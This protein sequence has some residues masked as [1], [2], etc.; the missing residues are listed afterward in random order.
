MVP[1]AGFTPTDAGFN[2]GYAIAKSQQLSPGIY[3]CMNGRIFDP[4]EVVKIISE[5]RFGS[6]Y[7]K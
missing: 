6:I 3:V 4:D 7:T 1:L 5:G 2:I